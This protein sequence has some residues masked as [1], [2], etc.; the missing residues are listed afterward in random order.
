[1]YDVTQM[2]DLVQRAKGL[3]GEYVNVVLNKFNDHVV[4]MSRMEKEYF[5]HFHPNSDEMFLGVEG[6]LILELENQR[7]QLGPGQVFT[8]ARGIPHRTLPAGSYSV[9]L[10]FERLDMETVSVD[11]GQTSGEEGK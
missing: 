4:R 6:V 5:W 3:S 11:E 2:I 8:V 1:M 7:I 9:N 10:T